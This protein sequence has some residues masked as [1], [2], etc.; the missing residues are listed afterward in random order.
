MIP[1]PIDETPQDV[2]ESDDGVRP[3]THKDERAPRARGDNTRYS[4]QRFS[5]RRVRDIRASGRIGDGASCEHG[6][7]V[8]VPTL[9]PHGFGQL[10][11]IVSEVR[12]LVA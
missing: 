1:G 2:E 6:D 4:A 7:G 3:G 10:M 8:T 12:V 11:M 5:C 9:A